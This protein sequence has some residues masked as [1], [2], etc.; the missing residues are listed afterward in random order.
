MH[1]ST[2]LGNTIFGSDYAHINRS[3]QFSIREL[4]DEHLLLA[5]LT[6]KKPN[7]IARPYLN[8]PRILIHHDSAVNKALFRSLF[9]PDLRPMRSSRCRSA[10]A[11]RCDHRQYEYIAGK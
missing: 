9:A 1:P 5:W 7:R 10:N 2:S 8:R 6:N 4:P 11:E 3:S